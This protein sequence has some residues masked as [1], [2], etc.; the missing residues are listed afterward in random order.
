MKKYLIF[1]S[2]TALCMSF[3]ACSDDNNNDEPSI[4]EVRYMVPPVSKI[5]LTDE[6][7]DMVERNNTFALNL[8]EKTLNKE[9]AG[10]SV[11]MSPMGVSFM[12]GMVQSGAN[13]AAQQQIAGA[14]GFGGKS[15]QD[16]NAWCNVFQTQ[17]P[18]IDQQ[19]TFTSANAIFVNKQNTLQPQFVED[20]QQYY[21]AGT[22]SLDF[23][24][25]SAV[26]TINQWS[27]SQTH[28]LIP[29]IL[30]GT[31]ANDDCY[32][33]NAVYYN[34]AWVHQF[35]K[36]STRDE[37]F[38]TEDG[39][40]LTLPMMHNKALVLAYD[41]TD[42]SMVILPYGS[43][44]WNMMAILPKNGKTVADIAGELKDSLET[45]WNHADRFKLDI[46]IPKFSLQTTNDFMNV[47][48]DLGITDIFTTPCLTKVCENKELEVTKMFQ[49]AALDVTE[50]G[51]KA[52]AVTVSSMGTSATLFPGGTFHV[53]HPFLYLIYDNDSRAIF[54]TGTYTGR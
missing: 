49:R 10:K 18:N 40:Q 20:M 33:L 31:S 13:D 26:A 24:S 12:L 44:A 50:E 54:F 51:S 45:A 39:T 32:L 11:F 37:T 16:I 14:L 15:V 52:T 35:D 21:Q 25:P 5:Q 17:T 27:N 9:E 42:F 2:L 34:A 3:T 23:S 47:L 38:T 22:G 19:V 53:D 41:G 1:I 30:Q 6:Q 43:G 48:P 29:Q 28:G 7:K 46:K 4:S 8:F 36:D